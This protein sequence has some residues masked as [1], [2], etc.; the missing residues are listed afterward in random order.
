VDVVAR[1][2]GEEFAV[3]LPTT[4]SEGA[5]EVANSICENLRG[6]AIAHAGSPFACVTVSIGCASAIPNTGTNPA[7]LI[8]QADQMLY[9]AKRLGRNHVRSIEL[10]GELPEKQKT[11]PFK[12]PSKA[13]LR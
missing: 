12:P 5:V 8:E 13:I 2:G 4:P 7:W 10:T 11:I 6:R 3:I 9:K 1:F